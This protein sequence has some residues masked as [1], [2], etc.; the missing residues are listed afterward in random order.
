MSEFR[1]WAQSLRH[2]WRTNLAV[3]LGV[4]A[5]TAVIGGALIVGDSVRG[6]LRQMTY[7]RLGQID[8]VLSGH[9]FFR[10]ELASELVEN[11]EF[12]KRF[13]K[14][15]P[16]LVLVGGME[17]RTSSQIRRV[18]NVN[19][20]GIDERFWEL[21][22]HDSVQPP[23]ETE[24]VLSNRVARQLDVENGD[25]ISLWIE[26]PATIPRDS[27]LGKREQ[28]TVEIE[29]TVKTVLSD[30]SKL[31]RLNLNPNQQL[32]LNAFVSLDTLQQELS[33]HRRSIPNRKLR[34]N[35]IK[36]ARVNTLFVQAKTDADSAGENARNA[37]Q[38]LSQVL[39]Q[40]LTPEDL[41]LR[42]AQVT[43][44]DQRRYLSLESEQQVLANEFQSAGQT[45][46]TN[47]KW[48]T[49]PVLVYLA[50]ELTSRRLRT[51]L[52][53][54]S[55]GV[56]IL[57]TM[58][59]FL[60]PPEDGRKRGWY[61]RYSVVAGVDSETMIRP[62]FGPFPISGKTPLQ[63][64]EIVVNRW[65]ADDLNVKPGDQLII[66]Y[67]VVGAHILAEN[68]RLPE[69]S[70]TFVV[71]DIIAL[72]GT[73]ADD[74]GFTP[75]V[76]GITDVDSFA[77]WDKPFPMKDITDRDD[78]YWKRY[79]PTP[80]A[81][82]S[83]ETAQ[84][85][86]SSRYGQLTSIRVSSP[87]KLSLDEAERRYRQEFFSVLTPEQSGMKFRPVKYEG[88]QAANGTTDFSSL[89]LGFS[90]FLILSAAIL[91][92]LL[93]RLGIEHRGSG[94]GLLEAVG[95]TPA[96]VRR[97]FLA[98]G[99]FLILVGG[100]LGILAAWGYAT[101][102]VYGLKTWWIGAIGTRFLFVYLEPQSLVIGFLS[103]AVV[104]GV[105]I[106]WA[107]RQIRKLS[108][109]ELL[110]GATELPLTTSGKQRRSRVARNITLVSVGLSMVLLVS[111]LT[112]IIPTSEAF[113]GLSWQVVIFFVI[114]MSMLTAGLSAFSWWLDSG[115]VSAVQGAGVFGIARLGLRNASRHRQ[116]S[117]FT[118]ALIASATFI[119]VAV[120][121]G[122]R[123]PAS[124]SPDHQSGNGGFTLVAETSSPILHD[125][126]TP[127][128]QRELK[129]NLESLAK[130]AEQ[131]GDADEAGRLRQ[132]AELL[133]RTTVYSF[134]VQPGEDASCL[135]IYQTRVPTILGVPPEFMERGGF[136][137]V[138]SREPNPWMLLDQKQPD[139]ENGLPVYPV[140]GDM[141]TLQYSLHKGIG[142]TISVPNEETPQ[143]KLKVVGMLDGSVFQGVLLMS[144]ANFQQL[145]P[146]RAGYRYFLIETPVDKSLDATRKTAD[147]VSE[148]LESR[149]NEFGFDAER[150]SDRLA[151]FLAVQ[152][153]YLSTFQTLGGLGL[154]LGTLGLATVMLRNVLE[155]RSELALLRAVGFR[156]RSLSLLVLCEN[157]ALLV[158]GLFSGT[159]SALLAMTPHLQSIGAAIPWLGIGEILGSVFV[160]GMLAALYAVSEAVRTPIISTLRAE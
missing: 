97:Q 143:Y 131:R 123:N 84:K 51:F 111:S 99:L 150:V 54:H 32:P 88:L 159:G 142:S 53:G 160:T 139:D 46:A 134:H 86:W 30:D 96:Q 79:G 39:K 103:S 72:E 101:L 25:A 70:H 10:E 64:N 137:F 44:R 120:A 118:V 154:L 2:Y 4:I 28:L 38:E 6:S 152:N 81:F 36:P 24:V 158:W 18:G 65:L 20:Y 104:A 7:D 136:K 71:R 90:F 157:A 127:A 108:A 56:G 21:T 16:A 48:D 82:I 144:K 130:Q 156:N 17:S 14:V 37:S 9:R 55:A 107:M 74:R 155:R 80:K 93:F 66:D 69:K 122:H 5:G 3:V 1:L 129:L 135:N 94:I 145:Y 68:G 147:E 146:D 121:A 132:R 61:S 11:S 98:E 34:K 73:V 45:A 47:L 110:S 125:L 109:R 43:T 83:L 153:T 19:V 15:A 41:Y 115:N 67:H 133:K 50:N 124:E 114:G 27:L 87:A 63:K 116:R 89:F 138:G 33:L 59:S 126:N 128:G 76:E 57:A 52:T 31:G 119:I 78:E 75:T 95:F 148:L 112:G 60:E 151:D 58:G 100:L 29:L 92:G 22:E 12:R 113:A 62:P 23:R 117:V 13:E 42:F 106:W 77:E 40:L 141:N 35:I 91:V 102:M 26:L 49:S 8:H 105:A 140:L 85:L 149:L